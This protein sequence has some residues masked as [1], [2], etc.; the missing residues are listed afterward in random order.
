M[1][2]CG[3]GYIVRCYIVHCYSQDLTMARI[4]LR[5]RQ[6]LNLGAERIYGL[7]GHGH[8]D[9]EGC[10]GV[11]GSDMG[12]W[13]T[14]F[15]CIRGLTHAMKGCLMESRVKRLQGQFNVRV[16]ECKVNAGLLPGSARRLHATP[17]TSFPFQ[18]HIKKHAAAN[19]LTKK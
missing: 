17:R 15:K 6:G 8:D 4:G 10:G 5:A 18:V 12:R 11:P 3:A 16:S 1:K 7:G 9:L 13:Q 2:I 19:S 14:R